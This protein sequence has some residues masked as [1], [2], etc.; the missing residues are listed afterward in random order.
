MAIED[1]R[2]NGST[3]GPETGG[4]MGKKQVTQHKGIRMGTLLNVLGAQSTGC[5]GELD[6]GRNS[7]TVASVVSGCEGWGGGRRK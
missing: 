3:G 2:C 5:V 6:G 7:R 1:C 4:R